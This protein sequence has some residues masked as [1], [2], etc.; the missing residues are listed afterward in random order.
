MTSDLTIRLKRH[1]DGSASLTLTRADGTV[2]WQRQNGS[3]GL[4]FPPHDLTHFAVESDLGYRQGFYGLVADGW[5]IADFAAPWPRGPIPEQAREVELIVGFFDSERRSMD[6]WS[7]ADFNEHA[8]KFVAAGKY[9]GKITPPAL[10]DDDIARVRAVRDELFALGLPPS[11]RAMRGRWGLRGEGGQRGDRTNRTTLP[12]PHRP[13]SP[14]KPHDHPRRIRPVRRRVRPLRR[15]TAPRVPHA[16]EQHLFNGR[17]RPVLPRSRS[18]TDAPIAR[19]LFGDTTLSSLPCSAMTGMGRACAHRGERR[20]AEHVAIRCALPHRGECAH[21]VLRGERGNAGM[22][23]ERRVSLGIGDAEVRRHRR[24]GGHSHERHTLRTHAL[25]AR[26][27]VDQPREQR[28][29]A[30]VARGLLGQ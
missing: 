7:A 26:H 2:T 25:R 5:E 15:S 8:L 20:R 27:R 16:V 12:F 6:R 18:S 24:A 29:F 4:V 3:L 17:A 9:A 1:S 28:R 22:H 21:H 13:H 23:R 11:R 19:R 14:Q 30:L 10:R